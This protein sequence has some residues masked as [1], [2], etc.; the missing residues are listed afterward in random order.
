MCLRT[1]ADNTRAQNLYE[2]LGFVE[3]GRLKDDRQRRDGS[4]G[5]T[6]LMGKLYTE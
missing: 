2:S 3:E 4:F 6:I 1:F 5:D